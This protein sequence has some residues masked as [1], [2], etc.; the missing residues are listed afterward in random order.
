M[1]SKSGNHTDQQHVI[2]YRTKT[3]LAFYERLHFPP[4][5]QCCSMGFPLVW[6]PPPVGVFRYLF[7]RVSSVVVSILHEPYFRRDRMSSDRRPSFTKTKRLRTKRQKKKPSIMRCTRT[8]ELLSQTVSC[9][10]DI[11]ATKEKRH[12][13]RPSCLTPDH[14]ACT[15]CT[16]KQPKSG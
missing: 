12:R 9:P 8:K 5:F 6:R 15:H 4:A 3:S 13:G 2:S 11:K 7:R 1:E 14:R 10:R 16:L